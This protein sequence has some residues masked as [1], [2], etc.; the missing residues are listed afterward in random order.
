MTRFE[1][2][3][4]IQRPLADVWA[5]VMEPANNAVWQGPIIEVHYPAGKPLELGSEIPE[6]VSFLGKRFT[7]TLVVTEHEPSTRSAVRTTSGPVRLDGS[8]RL[9]AV[10]EGS[11]RF[12]NEGV[13]EAHGFFKVA[14]PV[15][16]RMARREW[17]SS[18]ATLKDLL[19]AEAAPEAP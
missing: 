4:V 9:E 15:F 17:A 5:Y 14:E 1:H 19:E 18:C 11:T 16:A 10:D 13:V 6:V 12:T 3:V 8:Y 7:L 2:S